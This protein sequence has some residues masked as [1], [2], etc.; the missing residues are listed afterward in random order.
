VTNN[1]PTTFPLGT[2]TVTWTVTDGSG[3]TA[4]ATQTVTVVDNTNPTITAPA[5]VTVNANSACAAFN[6][7]LGT[8]VTADNCTVA[9]VTNNAPTVFPIGNTTV[10]WTVTDGVGNT[11]TAVQTVTIVDDIV[12]VIYA[13][14][15][16]ITY[17]NTNCEAAGVNL[18]LPVTSDN[19]TVANVVNDGLASYP[20]GTTTVTWTVTDAAGN[21]ATAQ[22]LVTVIDSISATPVITDISVNLLTT[23]PVAI[24]AQDVAGGSF[25]NC[26]IATIVLS[27]Y[28]FSCDDLGVN[29]VMVTIYDNS[30]NQSQATATVTVLPSGFDLDFDGIDDG[31]DTDINVTTIDVPNGFTPD[32]DNYN[33]KFVIPGLTN[34]ATIELSV[35]DRYGQL[36]Y[37][38]TNYANDWDGTS[39]KGMDLPDDTYF[40]VLTLDGTENRQGYVYINRVK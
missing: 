26:G 31:C 16:V 3:H 33:D 14:V 4:T 37:E 36:V 10:T 20:L 2:T 25:D 35:Y 30:G 7:A 8:P 9:S 27:K 40:Y 5:N 1:A 17:T 19:C 18:G 13:P 12:P 15:N 29:T 24:T 23:G 32:G 6:V 39:M 21:T 38:S 34:Y 11:A 22:Q 28:E